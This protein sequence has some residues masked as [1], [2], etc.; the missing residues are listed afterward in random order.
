MKKTK[1]RIGLVLIWV[2]LIIFSCWAEVHAQSIAKVYLN[3]KAERSNWNVSNEMKFSDL[4]KKIKEV[5]EWV[6]NRIMYKEKEQ[7]YWPITQELGSFTKENCVG[8]AIAKYGILRDVFKIPVEQLTL[9]VLENERDGSRHMVL[10][11][12]P[13]GTRGGTWILDNGGLNVPMFPGHFGSLNTFLTSQG[14]TGWKPLVGFNEE[15]IW[16]IG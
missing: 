10:A 15:K 2:G 16:N 14:I 12:Y 11:W 1:N 13:F 7:D 6:N 8:M 4:L 5:N 3:Q 9:I